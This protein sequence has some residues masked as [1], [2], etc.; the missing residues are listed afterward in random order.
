MKRKHLLLVAVFI[1]ANCCLV[2]GQTESPQP[3]VRILHNG[4]V[5][6]LHRAGLKPGEIIA[7]IVT[8]PCNFDTFPP[9]LRELRMKGLPDTVIMAMVMVPYGPA[10]SSRDALM[11]EEPVVKTAKVQVP[12][13][14]LVELEGAA[15]VSSANVA[16]GSRIN[17]RVSRRVFVNGVMVIDRGALA[18]ARVVKSKR[19]GAW[20]RGGSIDWVLEDVLAVDGSRIPIKLSDRLQGKNRSKAVV[21]AA[22][23]TGAAVFPYSPPAGLIWALKKGDEA[24]L[25]ESRKSTAVISNNTDV[26]GL[27]PK[28]KKL[29]YHT[30]ENLKA[31][32]TAR[33]TG[34]G[35]F[36]DSYRPTPIGKH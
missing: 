8:S 29:I 9:M 19:A 21:A 4:D 23:A 3:S 7:R 5:L 20:G 25:D 33:G 28:S 35:A 36:N 18:R 22:I 17:L 10:A 24:V 13:G 34:L 12:A 26:A 32:D 30:V 15:Q 27:Q 11:L 16:E 31:A 6:R 2:F 14:T 1:F